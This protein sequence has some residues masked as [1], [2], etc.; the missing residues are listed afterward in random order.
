MLSFL[1]TILLA[2]SASVLPQIERKL[3]TQYQEVR[4]LPGQLN[5]VLVFN[6]NSPE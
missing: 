5:D 6:S 4:Q 3:I 1:P 2:Q